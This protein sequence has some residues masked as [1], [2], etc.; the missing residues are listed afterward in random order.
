NIAALDRARRRA[1]QD[2]HRKNSAFQAALRYS[3]LLRLPVDDSGTTMTNAISIIT[4]EHRSLAAVLKGLLA[5][6]SE[7]QA[8][9]S[10]PDFY[11][12]AAMLDYIQ[13]IG[14]ASCRERG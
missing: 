2:G 4:E 13:E 7:A 12:A 14:R 9:R 8:G 1:S 5:H 6:V 10:M 11:L 3:G